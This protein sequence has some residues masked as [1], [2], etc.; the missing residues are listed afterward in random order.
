MVKLEKTDIDG[1]LVGQTVKHHDHRGWLTELFRSDELPEG[2]H[3]AMCYLSMTVPGG[4]RGPH[5]HQSQCDCL[6]FPGPG[7]FKVFLWDNRQDSIT[8]GK[9]VTL[10]S[11]E[12]D[13]LIIIIPPGIVHGYKNIGIGEGLVVNAPNRLYGGNARKDPIDEIRHESNPGSPFKIP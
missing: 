13:T 10:E 9:Q 8:W 7:R 5:E 12:S 6:I 11:N 1:V 3:P 4:V 2:F